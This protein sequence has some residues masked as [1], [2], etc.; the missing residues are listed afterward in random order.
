MA[1]EM[2]QCQERVIVQHVFADRHILEPLAAFDRQQRVFVFVRDVDRSEGP[3]VVGDGLSVLLGR[4][5][6]ALIE[7]VGLDDGRVL[8]ELLREQFLYPGARDDVRA[9]FFSGVE[10]DRQFA[11]QTIGDFVIDLQKPFRRKVSRE[12]D[13]RSAAGTF[14][15]R[16]IAFAAGPGFLA[17]AGHSSTSL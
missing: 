12:I 3:A 6:V 11:G 2:G 8:I 16:D 4:V 5:A 15:D 17:V 9:V 7:G 1:F 10:L 14:F 13:D